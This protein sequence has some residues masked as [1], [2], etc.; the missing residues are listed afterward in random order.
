LVVVVLVG[1]CV[2]APDRSG[3]SSSTEPAAIALPMPRAPEKLDDTAGFTGLAAGEVRAR[4]GDPSYRRRDAPAEI[5]Q[6]YGRSC[7]LDLFLYDDGGVQR[8]LHAE[9]RG[10]ATAAGARAACLSELVSGKRS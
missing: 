3:R 10:Q 6:Y 2:G 4:L 7:V 9:L 8:V 1:G 5:W